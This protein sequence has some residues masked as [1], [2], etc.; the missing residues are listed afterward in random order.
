MMNTDLLCERSC[1]PTLH[2]C[3][4]NRDV[5]NTAA[6]NWRVSADC[7]VALSP[8]QLAAPPDIFNNGKAVVVLPRSFP[9]GCPPDAK[10]RVLGELAQEEP[11]MLRLNRHVCIEIA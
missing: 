10:L 1:L 6:L 7:F 2:S 11:E 4:H 3:G 9:E 8:E 5:V